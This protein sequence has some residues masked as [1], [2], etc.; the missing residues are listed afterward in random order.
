VV[1]PPRP[2][3]RAATRAT[4]LGTVTD[5]TGAALPGV[6]VVATETRTNVSH[7]TI[8]NETGNFTFPNLLEGIYNVKP[9]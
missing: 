4:L 2:G 6:T 9:S 8:T 3:L 7:E 1:E 5:Q